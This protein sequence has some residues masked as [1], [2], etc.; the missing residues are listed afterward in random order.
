MSFGLI[1]VSTKP[2]QMPFGNW[3]ARPKQMGP[4][5]IFSFGTKPK[6]IAFGN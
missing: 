2:K 4:N 6:Q 5:E 1:W 3:M